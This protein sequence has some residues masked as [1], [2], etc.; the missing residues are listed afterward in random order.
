MQSNHGCSQYVWGVQTPPS[1]AVSNV[2]TESVVS[3]A[4]CFMPASTVPTFSLEPISSSTS[5]PVTL[6]FHSVAKLDVGFYANPGKIEDEYL[7][8]QILKEP[9]TSP[10]DYTFPISTKRNLRFQMKWMERFPWW[11]YSEYKTGA[12]CRICVVMRRSLDE[13]KGAISGSVSL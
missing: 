9:W 11:S 2:E 8:A 6:S 13:G 3:P 5:S 4:R 7:K 12:S 1:V 10:N